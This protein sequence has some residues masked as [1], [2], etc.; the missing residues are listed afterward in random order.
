MNYKI[1]QKNAAARVVSL[2]VALLM[3]VALPACQEDRSDDS[4]LTQS[5]LNS[6]MKALCDYNISSMNKCCM[7]KREPFDDSEAEEKSCRSIASLIEWESENISI[8]GNSA[9]AQVRI[10]LP[11]DI[12]SIC[13]AALSDTVK[14]LDEG[15]EEDCAQLLT[16]AIK[17]RAGK[18]KTAT[19]SAEVSMTKV[20][21]KWYIVKSLGINRILSDIR[22]PVAAV[23]ALIGR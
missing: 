18:A 8:D 16:S 3:M 7:A 5:L 13:S 20:D 22:T 9:I 17:K 19:L 14:S 10:T 2:I 11:E 4:T 15:S 21:N 1:S 23:F 6:Y 12:E